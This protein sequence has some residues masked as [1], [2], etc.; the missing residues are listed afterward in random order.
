MKRMVTSGNAATFIM[1]R[2]NPE[3]VNFDIEIKVNPIRGKGGKA[4]RK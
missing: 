1:E 4:K 2:E 3:S